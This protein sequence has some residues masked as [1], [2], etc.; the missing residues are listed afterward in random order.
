MKWLFY[1]GLFI[2]LLAMNANADIYAVSSNGSVVNGITSLSVAVA[3]ADLSGKTIHVSSALSSTFSNISSASVHGWPTD[4]KLVVDKGG[5]I[6]NTTTFRINGPFEAGLYQVFNCVSGGEVTFGSGAVTEIRPDWWGI[7]NTGANDASVAINKAITANIV[8]SAAYTNVVLGSGTFRLSSPIL[9]NR[10]NLI[11]TGEG[12]ATTLYPD[13]G[14]IAIALGT[15]TSATYN[16]L[17][18]FRIYGQ[19]NAT[20]GIALGD[21]YFTSFTKMRDLYIE[22]FKATG[23]YG[24][25][26]S[27]VQELDIFDC[28]IAGNYNGIHSPAASGSP[29]TYATSTTIHG[30]GGYIGGHTNVGILLEKTAVSFNVADIVVEDNA[31]GGIA[32]IND[33]T[34]GGSHIVLREVH[35]EDNRGANAIYVTG[36]SLQ[37]AKIN[38]KECFFYNKPSI[39]NRVFLRTD[40]V[41]D[42]VVENCVGLGTSREYLSL[43]PDGT[44]T[45]ITTANSRIQFRYNKDYNQNYYSSVVKVYKTLLGSVSWV[46]NTVDSERVLSGVALTANT[47]GTITTSLSSIRSTKTNDT[48]TI[49]A[50]FVVSGVSSPVG[51]LRITGLPIATQYAVG[52]VFAFGLVGTATTSLMAIIAPGSTYVVVSKYA[53]GGVANLAGDVQAGTNIFV[54]ISYLY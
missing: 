41:D 1:A 4:R 54:T 34:M 7:D 21:N 35:F 27:R 6:G 53:A 14:V 19:T 8:S 17:K 12:R 13:S 28:V 18:N 43:Y 45:I 23:S 11:L 3:R 38:I 22:N 52:N 44:P 48:I 36:T 24:I 30:K 15:T 42:S 10:D 9:I 2:V 32:A 33:N 51:E 31:G 5:S 25:K 26:L 40:Y 46:E 49:Y 37:P 50:Q 20:G 39:I 16:T 47:S 29:S